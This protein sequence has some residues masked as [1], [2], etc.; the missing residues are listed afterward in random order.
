[1]SQ[2][3]KSYYLQQM[4]I[5]CWVRRNLPEVPLPFYI[6]APKNPE[7]VVVLD[8]HEMMTNNQW[9]T[10]KVG[11]LLTKMLHS[12]G[13]SSENTAVLCGRSFQTE[14]ELLQRDEF[15]AEQI[16]RLAPKALLILG[17]FVTRYSPK[18]PVIFTIHPADCLNTPLMK[19][20]VFTDLVKMK[21]CFMI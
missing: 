8:D 13:L 19:R 16:I 15:L 6:I 20:K 10:G 9:P 4:G 14:Q 2:R 18:L 7:V 11:H 21:Q 17:N 5:D 1:M 12:I 3:L